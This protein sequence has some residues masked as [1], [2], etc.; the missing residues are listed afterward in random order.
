MQGSRPSL[1][2]VMATDNPGA[3]QAPTAPPQNGPSLDKP[4]CRCPSPGPSTTLPNGARTGLGD[5]V[6]QLRSVPS[7]R[8]ACWPRGSVSLNHDPAGWR[9]PSSH[10]HPVPKPRRHP[11]TSPTPGLRPPRHCNPGLECLSSLL[12]ASEAQ[13]SGPRRLGMLGMSAWVLSSAAKCTHG[14]PQAFDAF[15]GSGLRLRAL[16]LM[17]LSLLCSRPFSA[18]ASLLLPFL[19]L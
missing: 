1:H 7:R 8:L 19:S 5:S 9:M 3:H 16:S 18:S 14:P 4:P 12:R 6:G 15:S 2:V 13:G 17:C 11:L 10:G